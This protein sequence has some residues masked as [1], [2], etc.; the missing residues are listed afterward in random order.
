MRSRFWWGWAEEGGNDGIC[1]SICWKKT[2][3]ILVAFG[4]VLDVFFEIIYRK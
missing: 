1:L 4:S 2:S 3:E